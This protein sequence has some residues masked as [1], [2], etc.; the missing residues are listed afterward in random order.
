MIDMRYMWS[1]MDSG[2][3]RWKRRQPSRGVVFR[4]ERVWRKARGEVVV[5]VAVD[6]EEG[7]GRVIGRGGEGEDTAAERVHG[8]FV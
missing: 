4:R 5:V 6:E 7:L 8:A 3:G 1:A 2:W